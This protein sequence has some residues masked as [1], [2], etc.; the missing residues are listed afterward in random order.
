[1]GLFCLIR[2]VQYVRIEFKRLI[3]SAALL[4]CIVLIKRVF[5]LFFDL[6]DLKVGIKQRV[7]KWLTSFLYLL[8]LEIGFYLFFNHNIFYE[9]CN[10]VSKKSINI[11]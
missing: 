7:T 8:C 2:Q 10:E 1:M 6:H 11:K 3:F 5:F 4:C 9:N